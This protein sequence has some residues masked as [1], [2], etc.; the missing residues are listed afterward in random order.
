M[1]GAKR[2]VETYGKDLGNKADEQVLESKAQNILIVT[3]DT[4][5]NGI[6]TVTPLLI[7]ESIKTLAL[8]GLEI[9]PK[10][11]FDLS[12]I[13]EVYKENPELGKLPA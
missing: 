5:A 6:A 2:A 3:D 13:E 11:L 9:D 12:V 10:K 1:A 4:K 7:E 8:A